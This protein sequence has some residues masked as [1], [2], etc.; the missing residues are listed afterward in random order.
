[1]QGQGLGLLH[2]ANPTLFGSTAAGARRY[3]G[4]TP[5][6]ES[7]H[8]ARL[9]GPI[10]GHQGPGSILRHLAA[11]RLPAPDLPSELPR[12]SPLSSPGRCYLLPCLPHRPPGVWHRVKQD[13]I[14]AENKSR[15]GKKPNA[16]STLG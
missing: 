2:G 16:I 7:Q 14:K 9:K 13:F 10:L 1:M 3:L 15:G 6:G 11:T 12:T 4:L 8:R 5:A